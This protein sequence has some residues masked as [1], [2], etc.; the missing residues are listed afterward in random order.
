VI[1]QDYLDELRR[2]TDAIAAD[3]EQR[4]QL[5]GDPIA[6]HE[7]IME[8]TR[9]LPIEKRAPA[10]IVKRHDDA[11]IKTATRGQFDPDD[12][13]PD[14]IALAEAMTDACQ[15]MISDAVAPLAQRIAVI[16]AKLDVLLTLLGGN[17]GER[18]FEATETI[19][20][21]KVQR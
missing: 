18:S 2:E 3:L 5:D 7:Q 19:R 8:A 12:L 14:Q 6:M 20:K 11:R 1:D 13:P 9:P 16:E 4:E 17:G 21:L 15:D 10:V